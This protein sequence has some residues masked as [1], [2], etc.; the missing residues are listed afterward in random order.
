MAIGTT[1]VPSAETSVIDTSGGLSTRSMLRMWAQPL[2]VSS[3]PSQTTRMTRLISS[4]WR[5]DITVTSSGSPSVSGS[6][7][8]IPSGLAYVR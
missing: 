5:S 6:S 3:S 1:V 8:R 2:T 4:S 7:T